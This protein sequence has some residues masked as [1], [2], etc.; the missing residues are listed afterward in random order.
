MNLREVLAVV[1]TNIPI[2]MLRGRI[3]A[4]KEHVEISYYA[5]SLSVELMKQDMIGTKLKADEVEVVHH[6]LVK[7]GQHQAIVML[8]DFPRASLI[9]E[10]L[11]VRPSYTS[12]L[13]LEDDATIIAELHER[14]EV[15]LPLTAFLFK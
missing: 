9:E 1:P 8:V 2:L 15:F 5:Y 12:L 4:D 14:P 7:S 3:V 11:S 13:M 10:F 6:L